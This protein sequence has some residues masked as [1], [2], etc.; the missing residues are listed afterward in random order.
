M[1]GQHVRDRAGTSN[2]GHGMKTRG[3]SG[4]TTL[5]TVVAIA[6]VG[7]F[8]FWLYQRSETLDQDVQPV[9]EDTADTNGAVTLADLRDDPDG[10]AGQRGD[11][12]SVRVGQSL[13]RAVLTIR[14]DTAETA[15]S[16]P[17][18]LNTDVLQR[19]EEVYGGD[20]VSVVGRFYTLNDSIRQSWVEQ[21]AVE[22]GSAGELPSVAAFLLAD[23]LEVH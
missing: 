12:D 7:G 9:M 3:A 18:F 17:V 13:G 4:I 16:F 6:A 2:R 8:M 11:L 5:L 19:N 10:V 1:A 22:E 20:L 21:G 15:G 23:S 14:L